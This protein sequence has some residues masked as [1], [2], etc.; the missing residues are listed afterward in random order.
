MHH[1]KKVREEVGITTIALEDT[2][3]LERGVRTIREYDPGT[4]CEYA[5]KLPFQTNKVSM[6]RPY[7]FNHTV[8]MDVNYCHDFAGNVHMFLNLV[9]MGTGYQ[10]ELYIK[11]GKGTPSSAVCLDL[12]L[13]HW[14]NWASYP[15]QIISDR[16]LNNRGVFIKEMN[17]AGVYCSSIGLEAAN[18]LAKVERHG[19][20]WQSMAEVVVI[21]RQ[22]TGARM[23]KIMAAETTAVINMQNRYGGFS[24]SQWVV[25]RQPRHGG[26]Q[27]D[28]ET[29]HD[30]N[31]LEERVD[32]TTEFGERMRIR[33]I[34]K[35]AYVQIDSGRR[36]AKARLRKA[37]PKSGKYRVGD[38]ITYQ[39]DHRSDG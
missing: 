10:M 17:A 36:V 5:S 9:C 23:M 21:E 29:Y 22:I 32:P 28:D 39:R 25:G 31:T 6:P 19:G 4:D 16:G 26:E 14:V 27:G 11:E 8:G 35:K 15:K 33:H 37:A 20:M 7:E 30:L 18:Q 2:A 38:L 1:A 34:A 24:P 3:D 13:T 12:V